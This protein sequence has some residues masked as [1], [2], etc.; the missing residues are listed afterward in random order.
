MLNWFPVWLRVIRADKEGTARIFAELYSE[1][2]SARIAGKPVTACPYSP[3]AIPQIAIS[4]IAG[5]FN[6][7]TW[8]LG[9]HPRFARWFLEKARDGEAPGSMTLPR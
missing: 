2:Y 8:G 1:G 3:N 5:W 6:E 4:W 9:K 7:P